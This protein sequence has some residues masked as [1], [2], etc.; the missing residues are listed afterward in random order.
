M[1]KIIGMYNFRPDVP[2]EQCVRHWTTVHPGVV[3]R[4]VPGVQRYVQDVPVRMSRRSWPYSAISELWFDDMAAIKTAY[5][6][7]EL[8]AERIADES[9]FMTQEY[10]W[11][12]AEELVQW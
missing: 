11:L 7:P 1:L 9:I 2:L 8:A 6:S 10:S 3:R 5:G 4:T 12:I